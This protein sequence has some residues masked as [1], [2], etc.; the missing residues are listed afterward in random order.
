M[1]NSTKPNEIKTLD[2]KNPTNP[3]NYVSRGDITGLPLY[4]QDDITG[5]LRSTILAYYDRKMNPEQL[6]TLIAFLQHFIHAPCWLENLPFEATAQT[7]KEIS[8]LRTMAMGMKTIA[9][10]N[11]FIWRCLDYGI[12]PL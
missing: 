9:D 5:T 10:I 3:D 12:D 7:K 1:R 6:A 2:L 8:E 4:W 11:G